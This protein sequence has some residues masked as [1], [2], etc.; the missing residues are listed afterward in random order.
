MLKNYFLVTL[1]NLLKYKTYSFINIIGFSVALTPV[2]LAF[3][4]ISYEYSYDTWNK[5]YSRIY[6]VTREG[7][8]YING[9]QAQG[10]VM[11]GPF[12][13]ALKEEMPE[14]EYAARVLPSTET[15]SYKGTG[16][17]EEAVLFTDP[18]FMKIFTVEL[19]SG[20]APLNI[21][22]PNYIFFS[23]SMARK[24]FGAE[25]PIGKTVT[26]RG[27]Y[28]LTIRG[29]YKDLPKNSHIRANFIVPA[30]LEN[31][32]SAAFG[33]I[34]GW[35]LAKFPVYYLLKENAKSDA[36]DGKIPG[37]FKKYI[38]KYDDISRYF[39]QPLKYIHL[40]S[41][42][43][44]YGGNK[45]E[46]I[47][48]KDTVYFYATAAFMM[49][50]IACINYINLST[51][52]FSQRV[53][54]ISV[55]KIIGAG[56]AQLITQILTETFVLT[57]GSLIITLAL[58]A[59]I[60]PYFNLY[61]ERD[62]QLNFSMLIEIAALTCVISFLTGLY[63]ALFISSVQPLSFFRG[64][65]ISL[66]NPLFRK[67][68]IVVQFVLTVT[69]VFCAIAVKRQLDYATES[70][71]GYRTKDILNVN[72]RGI[73][74]KISAT[75]LREEISRYPGIEAASLSFGPPNMVCARGDVSFEGKP[76]NTYFEVSQYAIDENFLD[77]Y[78][79]KI[80][81]GRKY[82]K[83]YPTDIAEGILVNE[84]T[85]K[86]AGWQNPIGKI[87]TFNSPYSGLDNL[88]TRRIIGIVKDAHDRSF[89]KQIQSTMYI[90]N[91]MKNMQFLSVKIKPGN[92]SVTL[93]YVKNKL[94]PYQS[95]NPFTY[96]F[97]D[98]NVKASYLSEFKILNIFTLFSFCAVFISCLGLYGV[99]SFTTEIR[100]KEVG[101]R[102]VLGA[103]S[104]QIVEVLFKEMVLLMLIAGAL[105]VPLCY[106]MMNKWLSDFAYHIDI[107]PDIF[108]L[109]M[110]MVYLIA[111]VSMIYQ[112]VRASLKNPVETLKYE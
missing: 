37:L 108:I 53:K 91:I 96:E 55:R 76:A 21:S 12:A 15:I 24:Y 83:D 60:L 62:I 95:K 35:R 84:T 7:K 23:E 3:L 109:S 44:S 18:D 5:N 39:S 63:P 13:E 26:V 105:S 69:F 31:G 36:V 80:I 71:L 92:M 34:S 98:D 51:A 14:V 41:K 77:L 111:F 79:M 64:K 99:I 20:N 30:N 89:K 1:R 49:L 112:V 52:R 90:C 70:D 32:S 107:K 103:S 25:N 58:T 85:V 16:F 78:E 9:G 54:E 104:L 57:F 74:N 61:V 87:I 86:E 22:I 2:I 72:L 56:K 101:I 47:N 106:Y 88:E 6:R 59:S 81:K 19:I 43:K 42:F 33:N 100:S 97:L 94:A 4:F 93:N 29:V 38:G 50:L 102:K 110:F 11:P 46:I 73:D 10:C 40:N 82:S 67:T 66:S 28:D 65:S 68:L 27:L 48:G 45:S 75:A 8:D 17:T